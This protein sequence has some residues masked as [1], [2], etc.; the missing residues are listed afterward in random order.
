MA[1]TTL[2]MQV[3]EF[4]DRESLI[5]SLSEKISTH[6][7]KTVQTKETCSVA[8]AGGRTPKPIYGRLNELDLPWDQI[9]WLLGDERWVP[10]TSD[11]SNEF[12]VRDTLGVN[13]P[14]FDRTFWSW[15]L[16]KDPHKAALA[17][18]KRITDVL[19]GRPV[20]DL[21]LLG[22]G[23]D[24]HTASLFPGSAVLQEKRKFCVAE[25]MGDKGIRLTLTYPILNAARE[26]WFIVEG[27]KK[28]EMVQRLLKK[29]LTIPAA[30][31]SN[32][33]QQLFWLQ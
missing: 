24:G 3:H 7:R 15:H 6:I 16:D 5:S 9:Q 2:L 17:Y 11:Q 28:T 25:E 13:R 31:I 26:V 22:L 12:M 32:I 4:P 21:V 1:L 33:H 10:P 27:R 23:D 30:G 18:E 14:E 8:L 20:L 29:D 19:G